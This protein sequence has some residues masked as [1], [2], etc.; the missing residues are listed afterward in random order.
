M[1]AAT[2]VLR[3]AVIPGDGVG[4]EVIPAAL[5]VI[6]PAAERVGARLET[7]TFPW[8]SAYHART[9]RMMDVDALEASL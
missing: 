1:S 8:G 3:V 6:G 2:R 4:N 7:S 5:T 9:G